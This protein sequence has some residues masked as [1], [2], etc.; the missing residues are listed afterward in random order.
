MLQAMLGIEVDGQ[1]GDDTYDSLKVFQKNVGVK[2]NGT[3]GIDTWKRVI[4]HMKQILS[5]KLSPLELILGLFPFS[6]IYVLIDLSFKTGY[7]TNSR[8]GIELM[9]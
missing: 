4:E 5:D 2:A 6:Q 3:C 9:M 7:T 8:T 1:F